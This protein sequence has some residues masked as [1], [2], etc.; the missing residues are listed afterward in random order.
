[1]HAYN[2]DGTYVLFETGS[3]E[4][5][6]T[7]SREVY[8][9]DRPCTNCPIPRDLATI[10]Y[11]EKLKYVV[12]KNPPS[13]APPKRAGWV[14]KENTIL[15]NNVLYK[16]D[17]LVFPYLAVYNI[18]TC[19]DLKKAIA[20]VRQSRN[21]PVPVGVRL[22][23]VPL[24]QK[25]VKRTYLAGNDTKPGNFKSERFDFPYKLSPYPGDIQE[26]T[27]IVDTLKLYS[28]FLP[29]ESKLFSAVV[30]VQ[31]IYTHLVAD[32]YEAASV[33]GKHILPTAAIERYKQTGEKT[34]PPI[35]VVL[36]PPSPWIYNGSYKN[37]V[38]ILVGV[39]ENV[40]FVPTFDLTT[41]F[42]PIPDVNMSVLISST[43]AEVFGVRVK[44]LAIDTS[45]HYKLLRDTKSEETITY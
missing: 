3:P 45:V 37:Y 23:S 10:P 40:V 22:A 4:P 31:C 25:V 14:S 26:V 18:Q 33:W 2:S 16:V 12:L 34:F 15:L 38:G 7:W 36:T 5:T 17:P 32:F 21:L 30:N 41:P 13:T 19:A 8:R 44:Q 6:R 11:A 28:I 39:G 1:M 42:I 27:N 24:T 9:C 20:E 43:N 29:Q 35:W